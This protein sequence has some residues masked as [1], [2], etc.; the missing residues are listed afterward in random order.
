M[1]RIASLVRQGRNKAANEEIKHLIDGQKRYAPQGSLPGDTSMRLERF[2]NDHIHLRPVTFGMLAIALAGVFLS[3]SRRGGK[4]R[5]YMPAALTIATVPGLIYIATALFIRSFV[6][7]HLPFS[8]G[9]ETMLTLSFSAMLTSLIL[10]R[11][12]P[13]VRSALLLVAALSLL[14]AVM[15]EK[16]PQI[17]HLMPV[18][19]SPWLSIHVMLVIL[20][21]AAFALMAVMAAVALISRDISIKTRCEAINRVVLIPA[22]F[23]LGA[24]IMAGAVWA[25]Q[26]WGRYWGWDPKETCALITLLVYALPIHTVACPLFRR[27]RPFNI[28]I[29]TAIL[30]VLF[31]YF[32]ANYLLPGLHSYA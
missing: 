4:I 31:T 9:H 26:S 25:N 27:S 14:V 19:A 15:G 28:Y 29:L 16:N 20:S 7:G 30:A 21:Y 8:N 13:L 10:H 2:F 5:H 6:G 22:V 24:G 23:L 12:D 1:P 11:R 18:L 3:V 17:A 32:G